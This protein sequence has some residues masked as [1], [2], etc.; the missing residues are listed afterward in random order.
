[1]SI[2]EYI[3][4]ANAGKQIWQMLWSNTTTGDHP[5]NL[6]GFCAALVAQWL[7]ELKFASGVGPDELGR[8]LL[9]DDLG[10]HGYAGISNSQGIYGS[11]APHMNIN[12]ALYDRHS[13]GALSRSNEVASST[14]Q[15]HW[16]NIRARIYRVPVD[17]S[18][19]LNDAA[20]AY[21][22]HIS[23]S[24]NNSWILSK[25]GMGATWSHAIG[26]HSDSNRIYFF[27]P[28]YGVAILGSAH[29][30]RIAG[31]LGEVWR[32]YGVTRGC[33]ADIS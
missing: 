23:I 3:Q 31:F 15:D 16:L 18:I 14:A 22:G 13:G 9:Q 2:Q 26:V 10:R 20:G 17:D 27:D 19:R 4:P 21:S 33:I 7:L 32:Q 6:S 5:Y 25:L 24:G 1:M 11:H 28:N 29:Q 30:G 12:D 8:H